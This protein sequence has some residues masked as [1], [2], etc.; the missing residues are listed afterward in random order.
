MLGEMAPRDREQLRDSVEALAVELGPEQ[1]VAVRHAV[2][3]RDR[4]VDS[5]V[6]ARA[7]DSGAL[8]RASQRISQ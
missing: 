8:L 3:A 6:V 5:A 4:G 1:P 2:Q 7:D